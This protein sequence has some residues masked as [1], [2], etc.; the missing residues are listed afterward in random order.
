MGQPGQATGQGPNC[1]GRRCGDQPHPRRYGSGHTR[2]A[3]AKVT[4][5]PAMLPSE[6]S[7][8]LAAPKGIWGFLAARYGWH[9]FPLE[10]RVYLDANAVTDAVRCQ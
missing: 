3:G 4:I 9:L 1:Q 10:L 8:A 7:A 6:W 5:A 2:D